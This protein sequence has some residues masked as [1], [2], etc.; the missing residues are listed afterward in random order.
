MPAA[1]T[2][3]DHKPKTGSPNDGHR[4]T[5]DGAT[6]TLP[7]VSEEDAQALPG[8]LTMDIVERPEDPQVQGRYAFALLRLMVTDDVIDALR[9]LPTGQMMDILGD[10]MSEG[11]SGGSSEQ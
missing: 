1:K 5:V 3:Q 9:S 6:Y 2:P 4:F 8:S 10:W 7:P 11:E